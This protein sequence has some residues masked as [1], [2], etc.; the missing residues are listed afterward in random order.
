MK[1]GYTILGET[2]GEGFDLLSLFSGLAGGLAGGKKTEGPTA[3]QVREM[4]LQREAEEARREAVAGGG[5]GGATCAARRLGT[6]RPAQLV[7]AQAGLKG[8]MR[9]FAAAEERRAAVCA[10]G[11]SRR[12]SRER[13]VYAAAHRSLD[14]FFVVL[15]TLY[16]VSAPAPPTLCSGHFSGRRAA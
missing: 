15:A 12:E 10:I 13:V 5:G 6:R 11:P 3:A 1:T 9:A 14:F 7:A 16:L 2:V 8:A 4:Q